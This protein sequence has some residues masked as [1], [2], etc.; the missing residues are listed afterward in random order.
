[1]RIVRIIGGVAVPVVGAVVLALPYKQAGVKTPTLMTPQVGDLVVGLQI[2][3]DM[4]IPDPL[5][6]QGA[7]ELNAIGQTDMMVLNAIGHRK[8][9]FNFMS[10]PSDAT[11]LATWSSLGFISHGPA[12]NY[13]LV[14]AYAGLH[15]EAETSDIVVQ[16][17]VA[18]V[19]FR[20][21]ASPLVVN[22]TTAPVASGEIRFD[23]S[24]GSP[25]DPV[26]YPPDP[27]LHNSLG[28]SGYLPAV[29]PPR[30][31]IYDAQYKPLAG[32]SAVASVVPLNPSDA[33]QVLPAY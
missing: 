23:G 27:Y 9:L 33:S 12:G 4:L 7:V 13:S 30:F 32:K 5:L 8:L 31:F 26:T 29:T 25:L 14:F 11:G 20:G 24:Y 16:S 15:T 3:A 19:A 17:S 21:A 28:P 18:Y 22:L 2:L 1:M 10:N 6:P